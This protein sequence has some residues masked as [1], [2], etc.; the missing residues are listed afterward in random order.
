MRVDKV[1][2]RIT[3]I[4]KLFASTFKKMLDIASKLYYKIILI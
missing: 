3:Q 2:K 1:C 4:F